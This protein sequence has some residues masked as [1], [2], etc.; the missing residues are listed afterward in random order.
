MWLL[1]TWSVLSVPEELN[2]LFNFKYSLNGHMWLVAAMLGNAILNFSGH[3]PETKKQ[4][5]IH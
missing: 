2:F 1:N 3:S 5:H 4:K